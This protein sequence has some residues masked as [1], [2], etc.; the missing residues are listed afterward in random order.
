MR[1]AEQKLSSAPVAVPIERTLQPARVRS[2]PHWVT[3]QFTH[4]IVQTGIETLGCLESAK[5]VGLCND[6]RKLSAYG[7]AFQ[8]RQDPLVHGPCV[9]CLATTDCGANH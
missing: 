8:N 4:K 2:H 9:F 1:P 7:L 6:I 3:A 5:P